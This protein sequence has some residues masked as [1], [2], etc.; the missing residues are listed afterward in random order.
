MIRPWPISVA[1]ALA[2]SRAAR[3]AAHRPDHVRDARR[4]DHGGPDR[5]V[6]FSRNGLLGH[7]KANPQFLLTAEG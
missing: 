4:E 6:S 1:H 7:P 5:S 2:S 3:A